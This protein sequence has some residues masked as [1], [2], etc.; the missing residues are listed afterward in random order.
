M[1]AHADLARYAGQFVWLEINLDKAANRQ[2]LDRYGVV[3]TPTFYIIDPQDGRVAATVSAAMSYTE[4]IS[5]LDRGARGVL[6]KRQAPAD[7]AL[8]RGD[9]LLARKPAEAVGEY[10]EALQLASPGWS[11]HDLAEAS[12]VAAL[13]SGNDFHECAEIA[14]AEASRMRRGPIFTRTVVSGMWCLASEDNT[15]LARDQALKL[16]PLAEEALSLPATERDHRDEL[17]RTL[18]ILALSRNDKSTAAKWGD[19]WLAELD[20]IRP[21]SEEERTAVDIARVENIDVFGDPQRILPELLASECAMPGSWNASLRVAQMES[22]AN[23]FAEAIAACERGLSRAPGPL[24]RSWLLQ[25]KASALRE[26]G[27]TAEARSAL[28]EALQIA[29]GIPLDRT[30][31]SNVKRIKDALESISKEKSK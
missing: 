23:K 11:Q 15:Q 20:A 14:A 3:G 1:L 8:A 18:M 21:A 31:E 24:G 27:R 6:T 30:R 28:E 10:R 19:R 5:F 17:Y 29:G 7:A 2:F 16:Q 25:V 22:K 26:E 9:G 13:Q 12:L 4:F